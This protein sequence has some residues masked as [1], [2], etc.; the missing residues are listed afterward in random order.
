MPSA[1]LM[2]LLGFSYF[3]PI[4]REASLHLWVTHL[5]SDS[6]DI[7]FVFPFASGFAWYMSIWSGRSMTLCMLTSLALAYYTEQGFYSKQISHNY[8]SYRPPI[9][10]TRSKAWALDVI[11]LSAS[12]CSVLSLSC[13]WRVYW[14][15]SFSCFDLMFFDSRR[16]LATSHT[17]HFT[18]LV[19]W[20]SANLSSS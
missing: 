14:P 6:V 19:S 12:Y 1:F 4:S 17:R 15:I 11:A 9:L 5:S 2:V 20:N 10:C 7:M 8:C 3:Y 18:H 16:H 13:I